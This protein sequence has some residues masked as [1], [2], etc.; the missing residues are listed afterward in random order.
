MQIPKAILDAI[1]EGTVPGYQNGA[2]AMMAWG[3]SNFVG[4]DYAD[5][6]GAG[7]L[8]FKVHGKSFQGWV[9]CALNSNRRVDITFESHSN[10]TGEYTTVKKLSNVIHLEV[11]RAIDSFVEGTNEEA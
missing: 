4:Q 6:Y 3:A 2:H 11:A 1:N 5:S 10:K 8:K 9:R 7:W